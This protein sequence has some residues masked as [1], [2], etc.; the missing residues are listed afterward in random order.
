MV[1]RFNGM[2]IIM[3]S[4][5]VPLICLVSKISHNGGI[6]CV[7]IINNASDKYQL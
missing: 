6:N 7:L 2:L 3:L 5:F 4:K 1:C